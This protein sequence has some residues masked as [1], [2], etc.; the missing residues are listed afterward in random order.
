M[1]KYNHWIGK[2]FGFFNNSKEYAVTFG[3]TTYYSCDK[4][5][6]DKAPWWKVHEDEHKKQYT[7][8]GWFV[9]LYRY[10]WQGLTKGYLSIDYE[11]EARNVAI[12][13]SGPNITNLNPKMSLALKFAIILTIIMIL[14]FCLN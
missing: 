2:I 5:I 8:D 13:F 1:D 9:F 4:F 14:F 12:P 7:T 10:I 3:Q 6:V 11:I